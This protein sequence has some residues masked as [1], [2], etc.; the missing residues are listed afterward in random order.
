LCAADR[1]TWWFRCDGTHLF[2]F[3]VVQ[4]GK[5]WT[6]YDCNQYATSSITANGVQY[7]CYL[8]GGFPSISQFNSVTTCNCGNA[9]D[10]GLVCVCC[11]FST[12]WYSTLC[13]V[14][15]RPRCVPTP[16]TVLSKTVNVARKGWGPVL[17]FRDR[18]VLALH[19]SGCAACTLLVITTCQLSLIAFVVVR[20]SCSG[21]WMEFLERLLC[22]MWCRPADSHLRQSD[23]SGPPRESVFWVIDASVHWHQL[24]RCHIGLAASLYCCPLSEFL[25]F[26]LVSS[27]YCYLTLRWCIVMF[28]GSCIVF[29]AD[30]NDCFRSSGQWRLEYLVGMFGDVRR[31]NPVAVVHESRAGQRRSHVCWIQRSDV[32][33][34]GVLLWWWR[35]RRRRWWWRISVASPE[36]IE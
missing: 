24:P 13:Q 2:L 27:W 32:L 29:C 1:G 35:R 10:E 36:A 22:R 21:R 23:A 3:V 26:V 17:E 11:A 25:L 31:R 18:N 34:A 14:V 15:G 28:F 20:L 6:G 8:N 7:C 4:A 33:H 16:T 30:A 9:D 5:C 19:L 12:L